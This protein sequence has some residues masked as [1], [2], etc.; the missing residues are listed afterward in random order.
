MH[1]LHIIG[2]TVLQDAR[3]IYGGIDTGKMRQP[4]FRPCCL[5]NV[6]LNPPH[7][8]QPLCRARDIAAY[9]RDL[10]TFA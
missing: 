4:V 6:E 8:R 2:S 9:A 7:G 5:C 3:T 1:A 10:M